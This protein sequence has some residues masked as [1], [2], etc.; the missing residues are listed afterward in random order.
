ML[1]TVFYFFLLLI[2]IISAATSFGL[3]KLSKK[4]PDPV[5]DIQNGL[6]KAK[7]VGGYLRDFNKGVD[8]YYPYYTTACSNGFIVP[9][10]T[11]KISFLDDIK[12]LKL[13]VGK[14]AREAIDFSGKKMTVSCPIQK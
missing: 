14:K 7:E 13:K 12:I 3:Y 1:K 4:I 5:T 9:S 6:D 10:Y 8:E 2:S 11:D